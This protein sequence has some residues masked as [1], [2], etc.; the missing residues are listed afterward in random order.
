MQLMRVVTYSI[1]LRVLYYMLIWTAR[2][3]IAQQSCSYLRPAL[4]RRHVCLSSALDNIQLLRL[5]QRQTDTRQLVGSAARSFAWGWV[6][7]VA[8]IEAF[9][10]LRSSAL[11]Y[12]P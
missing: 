5:F 1:R 12:P 7:V 4:P 2:L 9:W 11:L 8:Y 6:P 10:P 3:S